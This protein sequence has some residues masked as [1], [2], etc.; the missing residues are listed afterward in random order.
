MKKNL[1]SLPQSLITKPRNPHLKTPPLSP[2]FLFK[3]INSLIN[4]NNPQ[5]LIHPKLMDI[6]PHQNSPM[7]RRIRIATNLARHE[8]AQ[9]AFLSEPFAAHAGDGMP[10]DADG[11]LGSVDGGGGGGDYVWFGAEAE[12]VGYVKGGAEEGVVGGGGG[13]LE[14][15]VSVCWV[16]R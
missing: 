11:A 3:R 2:L 5:P 1:T 14:L 4:I 15:G 13:F 9:P 8:L 7:L 16:R 6:I 12:G 10:A